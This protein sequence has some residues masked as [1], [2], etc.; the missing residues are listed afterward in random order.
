MGAACCRLIGFGRRSLPDPIMYLLLGYL[1]PK[2]EGTV[3]LPIERRLRLW[4]PG[5][6]LRILWCSQGGDHPETNLANSGYMPDMKVENNLDPAIF[7]A[8]YWNLLSKSGDFI[9]LFDIWR[10]WTIFPMKNP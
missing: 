6:F 9:W 1:V 8:T 10:I 5:F 4:S 3:K 7:L 2:I